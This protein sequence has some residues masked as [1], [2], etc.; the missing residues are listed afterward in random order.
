M[1]PVSALT[2]GLA[3]AAAVVS[4]LAGWLGVVSLVNWNRLRQGKTVV[5]RR[6]AWSSLSGLLLGVGFVLADIPAAGVL[7]LIV[8]LLGIAQLPATIVTLP[9][10]AYLW[11]SGDASTASN[12]FFT[13]YLLVAGMADNILKPLLL[14]RGVDAPMPVILLGAMGGM[15]SSGIIGLFVGAVL[16]AVGYQIF[17]EWVDEGEESATAESG[18][19]EATA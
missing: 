8:L 1:P 17:M 11:W 9:V 5:W 18:Q 6:L 3:A 13:V 4:F 2:Y 19:T 12:V 15:V 16:L 10:I 7:A 14:G